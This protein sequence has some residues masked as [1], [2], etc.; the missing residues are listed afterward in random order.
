MRVAIRTFRH[1]L[2]DLAP[3][4]A[5]AKW[6]RGRKASGYAK[7]APTSAA[8]DRFYGIKTKCV[9]DAIALCPRRVYVGDL[10]FAHAGIVG[11]GFTPLG[12][13]HVP[14]KTLAPRA[15]EVIERKLRAAVRQ[16]R[17]NIERA[18]ADNAAKLA[19]TLVATLRSAV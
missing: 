19:S 8:R 16:R 4:A 13:L 5:C 7:V 15:L 9:S 18:R 14:V 2:D 11:I 17:A 10:S 6:H 3:E 12:Q 1:V